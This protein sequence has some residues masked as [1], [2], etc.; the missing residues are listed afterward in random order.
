MWS[1]FIRIIHQHREHIARLVVDEAHQIQTATYRPQFGKIHKLMPSTCQKIFLSASI[2]YSSFWSFFTEISIS[3]RTPIIKAPCSQP[4]LVYHIGHY[5]GNSITS[6]QI[7]H[8]FLPHLTTNI[9]KPRDRGIIFACS[10]AACDNLEKKLRNCGAT[11]TYAG[12]SGAVRNEEEWLKGTYPWIVSTTRMIH[13]I[14]Y[15][16]VRAVVFEEL[17]YGLLNVYQGAG[18]AGRDGEPGYIFALQNTKTVYIPIPQNYPD[19]ECRTVGEA[20]LYSPTCRR[21]SFHQLL[22]ATSVTCADILGAKPC[23]ICMPDTELNHKFQQ[24]LLHQAISI[25]SQPPLQTNSVQTSSPPGPHLPG[26]TS[27]PSVPLLSQQQSLTDR[28]ISHSVFPSTSLP[29]L[30]T[31]IEASYSAAILRQ[32]RDKANLLD[33]FA[34][35]LNGKCACCWFHWNELN[36][37]DLDHAKLTACRKGGYLANIFGWVDMKKKFVFKQYDYCYY[38]GFPQGSY[39]P[40]CHG[41][42]GMK[43]TLNDSVVLLLWFIFHDRALLSQIAQ[44]FLPLSKF[45]TSQASPISANQFFDWCLQPGNQSNSFY[46]GL[47]LICVFI[48]LRKLFK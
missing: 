47:E 29:A 23:D 22:D 12:M 38:C 3:P 32:K 37:Q 14:D 39:A 46:M 6:A 25:D 18:R 1:D 40:S 10:K 27:P 7:L 41:T 2:P 43:C 8:S 30:E 24:S 16:H 28:S 33:K 21:L 48:K 42:F 44:I 17:P 34:S 45:L 20:W 4:Q 35:L 26:Q 5:N 9:F 13:G 15:A 11:K 36:P 19:P 31:Q